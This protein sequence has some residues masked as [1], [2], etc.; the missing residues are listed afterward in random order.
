MS[1]EKFKDIY[2]SPGL[3]LTYDDLTTDNTASA[4]LKKQSGSSTDLMFDYALSSDKRD[5]RFMPTAGHLTSFY[6]QLPVF[7][8]Q[9]HLKNN[10]ST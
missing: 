1:Y 7:A 3:S 8:D 5:R 6:Q 9:P 10:F 4:L 2:F